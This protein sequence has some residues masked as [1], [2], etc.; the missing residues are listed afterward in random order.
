[1]SDEERQ[2]RDAERLARAP[3]LLAKAE[4]KR[5]RRRKSRRLQQHSEESNNG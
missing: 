3:R 2:Q 4:A 1:M 5:E